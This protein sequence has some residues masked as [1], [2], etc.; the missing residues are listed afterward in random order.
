M[1]HYFC[2]ASRG[3]MKKH[4][5]IMKTL[6]CISI[7]YVP[8]TIKKRKKLRNMR[9]NKRTVFEFIDSKFSSVI[10]ILQKQDIT[11]KLNF[12]QYIYSKFLD[13]TV[14]V[15]QKKEICTN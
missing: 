13:F 15:H 9:I 5:N 14:N 2:G 11:A 6:T 3:K 8:S 1:I 12:G 4:P 7:L 10:Y